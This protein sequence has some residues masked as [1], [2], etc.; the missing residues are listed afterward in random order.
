MFYIGKGTSCIA[1]FR[2]GYT[3]RRRPPPHLP[4]DMFIQTPTREE[5]SFIAITVFAYP[6]L[7]IARFMQLSGLRQ[8]GG[9]GGVGGGGIT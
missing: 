1:R 4:A 8:R 6:P 3:A 9:G 2:A 5:F 7:S